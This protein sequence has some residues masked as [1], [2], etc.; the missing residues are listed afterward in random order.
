MSYIHYNG[1]TVLA[2]VS[3]KDYGG[4]QQKPD[5]VFERDHKHWSLSGEFSAPGRNNGRL[6]QLAHQ[7]STDMKVDEIDM[8]PQVCIEK[9][10][11]ALRT[12]GNT[13]FALTDR[14]CQHIMTGI[15]G[16]NAFGRLLKKME[17]EPPQVIVTSL[18][19]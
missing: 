13:V 9:F 2:A 11:T 6:K 5:D 4:F 19:L 15:Q 1:G 8:S 17:Q 16:G 7:F 18:K 14:E 3:G 12:H 10:D